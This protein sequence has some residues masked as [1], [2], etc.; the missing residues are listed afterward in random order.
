MWFT[1][2]Y[3]G[4]IGRVS[5]TAD[6][7]C[8]SLV[9]VGVWV[10]AGMKGQMGGTIGW[11][12]NDPKG[13]HGVADASGLQLFG[14]GGPAGGPIPE[15]YGADPSFTYDWA[16]TFPYDDPFHPHAK[17]HV[18]V[19]MTVAAVPGTTGEAQ[20]SW[21]VADAPAGDVF[22]VQVEVPGSAQ[23]V[24]WQTAV[25]DLSAVFGPSDP[26]WAGSGKY[27]F[28]SSLRQTASGAASAYSPPVSISL[29]TPPG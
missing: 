17:G 11:L 27:R 9:P 22:D 16:G 5:D 3:S 13:T 12:M 19:P 20:A 6:F 28:R 25:P 21:A 4:E 26:L 23:F 24:D 8:A 15:P 18:A 29:H 10:R 7:L 1:D 2:A 14:Y